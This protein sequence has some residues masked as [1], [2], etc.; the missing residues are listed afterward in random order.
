MPATIFQEELQSVVA[1]FVSKYVRQASTIRRTPGALRSDIALYV[2]MSRRDP[3]T[4]FC[5]E[6]VFLYCYSLLGEFTHPRSRVE[7]FVRDA[8]AKSKGSWSLK[9]KEMMSCVWY[10]YSW[11]EVSFDDLPNG[12]KT[13]K[14][15]RTLDPS[16]YNFVG[17]EEALT[18]VA[19]NGPYGSVDLDYNTGIHL[20]VGSEISFDENYGCGRL[21]TAYPYW[22]LHQLLMPVLAI[23]AQRQATPILVKKTETGADIALIDQIS[24]APILDE[25]G[26]PTLIKKGWD[27]VRQLEKL[28][29]A[30]VTA[31]DPDDDL[32][33]IE[34]RIADGFL[35][36]V[37]QVCKQ[38]R[39]LSYLVP[40]TLATISNQGIGDSGLSERHLE[41]FESI[42]AGIMT[43]LAEEIIE[44]L[45]RPLIIFNFGEMNDYGHFPIVRTNPD[46]LHIAE[47]A[48]DAVDRGVL[49]KNDL[50]VINVI[51][52]ALGIDQ[53][54]QAE[55]DEMN[56]ATEVTASLLPVSVD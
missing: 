20:V 33:Q 8:I 55:F 2:E 50:R 24:G 1:S 5:M 13:F 7:R 44:Q 41:I 36:S 19:Y 28:G 4:R 31:I 47:L 11:T 40:E 18:T 29:S 21:E 48:I 22:E 6:L 56:A 26:E 23:A 52:E 42:N 10:G 38:Q 25:N 54:S 12:R 14:Q 17:T 49:P 53:L 30:G 34:P 43:H 35:D 9:V 27:A 46:S 16:R 32:Y 37:F 3:M 39:A 45:I 51:R 15:F